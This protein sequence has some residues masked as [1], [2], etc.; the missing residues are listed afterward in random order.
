MQNL[1]NSN[2]KHFPLTFLMYATLKLA[3]LQLNKVNKLL[4]VKLILIN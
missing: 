4:F 3:P 2:S 1:T